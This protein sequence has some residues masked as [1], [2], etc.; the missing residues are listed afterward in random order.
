MLSLYTL[1]WVEVGFE[2]YKKGN[3]KYVKVEFV[4]CE[5]CGRAIA[6]GNEFYYNN[7]ILCEKCF[8]KELEENAEATS[9]KK[10]K[11]VL[12]RI[13]RFPKVQ[14]VHRIHHHPLI[15]DLLKFVKID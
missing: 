14:K 5:D 13:H 2:L 6:S 15:E 8:E 9:L 1:G 11:I 7:K 10:P 3:K 12:V 4:I